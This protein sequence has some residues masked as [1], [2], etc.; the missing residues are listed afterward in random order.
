MTALKWL[1]APNC[2]LRLP[3][4]TGLARCEGSAMPPRYRVETVSSPS[5]LVLASKAFLMSGASKGRSS[6]FR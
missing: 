4:S 3:L 6:D 1:S 5:Y 2:R